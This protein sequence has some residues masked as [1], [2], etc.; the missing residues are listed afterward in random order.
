MCSGLS[1]S[2]HHITAVEGGGGRGDMG[3]TNDG[4]DENELFM[5]IQKYLM[6]I[7]VVKVVGPMCAEQE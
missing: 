6:W 1:A 2:P 3:P 7:V 4:T 5:C